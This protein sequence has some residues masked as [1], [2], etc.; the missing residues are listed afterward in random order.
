MNSE[1]HFT[2]HQTNRVAFA[3]LKPKRRSKI[4]E[5]GHR[6]QP[7]LINANLELKQH[8]ARISRS[9]RPQ[10]QWRRVTAPIEIL[11]VVPPRSRPPVLARVIDKIKNPRPRGANHQSVWALVRCWALAFR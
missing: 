10:V 7:V 6:Y 4:D 3:P 1:T 9:G 5:P 8:R 2:E 11:E